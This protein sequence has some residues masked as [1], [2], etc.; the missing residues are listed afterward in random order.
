V[1][2]LSVVN[3]LSVCVLRR[4]QLCV[5]CS[6]RRVSAC[7]YPRAASVQP[8]PAAVTPYGTACP[9]QAAAH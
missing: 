1:V 3:F 7:L 5:R 2:S 4:T 9:C 8:K 6:H